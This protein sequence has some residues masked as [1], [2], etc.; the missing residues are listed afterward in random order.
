MDMGDKNMRMRKSFPAKLIYILM[1][2]SLMSC[3]SGSS[4]G[5]GSHTG[6]VTAQLQWAERGNA[7][8]T[9]PG[10]QA[11][12]APQGVVTVRIVVSGSDMSNVQKDFPAAA[13]TG[14]IDGV[15]AGTNRTLTAQGLDASGVVT[16]Q[17]AKS[18]ITVQTGQTT[19]AGIVVMDPAGQAFTVSGT[20]TLNGSGL[21]G[22]A[23]SLQ[24]TSFSA[25]TGPDGVYSLPGIPNAPYTVIPSLSGYTFSPANRVVPD[26]NGS[27]IGQDFAASPIPVQTHTISGRVT[28]N[29]SGLAGVTVSLQG[30][31]FSTVTG[32]DGSY[33]LTGVPSGSYTIVP[34]LAGNLFTPAN[35]SVSVSNSDVSGQDLTATAQTHSISGRVTL[36]GSGLAGVAVSLQGTSSN[37]ATTN[38]DGTYTFTGIQ[39]G[40]YTVTPA[41]AGYT[42]TPA[43]RSVTIN[44]G[45]MTGEDF[46]SA[47]QTAGI[48]GA[49]FV[50]NT[51]QGGTEEGPQIINF[52]QTATSLV[53]TFVPDDGSPKTGNATVSSNNVQLQWTDSDHCGNTA[54]ISLAGTVSPDGNTISGT[55]ILAGSSSCGETGTWRASKP[56]PPASDV[57]GNWSVFPTVQGTEQSPFCETFAQVGNFLTFSGMVSGMGIISGSSVQLA[58]VSNVENCQTVTDVTGTLASGGSSISGNYLTTSQCGISSGSSPWRAVKGT[59]TPTPPQLPSGFP[60]NIPTGNY[61]IVVSACVSG[62]CASSGSFPLTNTDINQFAQ[63]LL[64]ALDSNINQ[65]WS[66]SCQASGCTCTSAVTNYTPWNGTSFTITDNFSIVCSSGPQSVSLQ[67]TVTKL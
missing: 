51:P 2:V 37:S 45:D 55:Y 52:T 46:T 7:S 63:A 5:V 40:L 23:V 17:G 62:N 47:A 38:S 12:S 19:D 60:S 1:I 13:G 31:S 9:A 41:L 32:P 54:T 4:T 11:A 8:L 57:S 24:G 58:L 50:F 61:S 39:N 66:S 25:V 22:V 53:F 49:W 29:G 33:A 64:N 28:L 20:V 10:K 21:A 3:G 16:H 42:F 6:S 48:S 65:S 15:P 59:C 18:N 14:V 27:V 56:Q 43:N 35:I 44:N 67:F 26:G 36:N 34:L 30:T